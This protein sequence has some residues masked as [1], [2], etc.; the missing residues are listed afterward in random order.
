M[1]LFRFGDEVF[2]G[3][4]KIGVEDVNRKVG[5]IFLK[6]LNDVLNMDILVIRWRFGFK[7]GGGFVFGKRF[8]VCMMFSF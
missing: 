6:S 8:F 3:F 1:W 5:N 2:D 7:Y 4:G